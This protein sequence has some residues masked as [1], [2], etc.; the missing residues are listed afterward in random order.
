MRNIK[1]NRG[2]WQVSRYVNGKYY[3]FGNYKTLER[4]KEMR[5][6]FEAKGWENCLDER[7]DHTEKAK[8]YTITHNGNYVPRKMV[9]GEIVE[10]ALCFS[11]EQCLEE[12]KLM[13]ICNWDWEVLC[14]YY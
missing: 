13:E 5:D 6:Y 8:H 1:K 2:S 10:G 9:N 3:S 12:I 14:A 7:L 4:A 11:L